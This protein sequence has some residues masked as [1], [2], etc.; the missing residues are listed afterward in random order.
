MQPCQQ[1][2]NAMATAC[3]KAADVTQATAVMPATSNSEDDSKTVLNSR[4]ANNSTS[5]SWDANRA[6]MPETV[7]TKYSLVFAEIREKLVRTAKNS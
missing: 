3:T 1:Q 4:N 2:Q 7:E 5:I 6:E